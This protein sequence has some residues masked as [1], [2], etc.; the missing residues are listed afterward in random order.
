MKKNITTA[1]ATLITAAGIYY[2]GLIS[3][4]EI[5]GGKLLLGCQEAYENDEIIVIHTDGKVEVTHPFSDKENTDISQDFW[6]IV[7]NL[8]ETQELEG[9]VALYK[10]AETWFQISYE[11]F[12]GVEDAGLYVNEAILFAKLYPAYGESLYKLKESCMGSGED[13]HLHP[14]EDVG[15]IVDQFLYES[16]VWASAIEALEEQIRLA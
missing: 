5:I 9:T 2:Q 3:H 14:G 1:I 16:P 8:E 4:K 13:A 6:E 11:G 15:I 7:K 10:L 12:I